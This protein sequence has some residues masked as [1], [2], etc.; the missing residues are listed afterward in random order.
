MINKIILKAISAVLALGVANVEAA[1]S[2]QMDEM[3]GHIQGQEKCYGVAKAG[4]ND[5]GTAQHNCAGEAKKDGAKEDWVLM[6]NGL[7]KK[8]VGASSHADKEA[9][10]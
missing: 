1:A 3:M 4:H 2:T 5:C 10:S 9:S 6:P 7:C 8:I